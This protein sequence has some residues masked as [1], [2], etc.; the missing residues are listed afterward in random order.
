MA[1]SR[2]R[3]ACRQTRNCAFLGRRD[4]LYRRDLDAS[5]GRSQLAPGSSPTP[6]DPA[7][8]R[9][10]PDRSGR[11]LRVHEMGSKRTRGHRR[12]GAG[13]ESSPAAW[14]QRGSR[15]ARGPGQKREL[16]A[17]WDSVRKKKRRFTRRH[18]RGGMRTPGAAARGLS[19]MKQVA[20][21]SRPQR[22][23]SRQPARPTE[24]RPHSAHRRR[25]DRSWPA[26]RAAIRHF[27]GDHHARGSP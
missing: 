2:S 22:V 12:G 14:K 24:R 26:W 21:K 23:F 25:P 16:R 8:R 5:G 20:N 17:S 27:G 19:L 9:P 6:R 15:G 13:L 11:R 18:L 1:A 4:R 10:D 7:S 3:S